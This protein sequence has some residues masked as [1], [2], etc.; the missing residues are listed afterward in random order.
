MPLQKQASG[1]QLVMG[2]ERFGMQQSDGGFCFVTMW[3]MLQE[4]DV[5]VFSG[6]MREILSTSYAQVYNESQLSGSDAADAAWRTLLGKDRMC[7]KQSSEKLG[8][9]IRTGSSFDL[10]TVLCS[11]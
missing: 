7:H 4:I 8:E 3:F 11:N 5:F 2:D 1:L 10:F 9:V 6:E